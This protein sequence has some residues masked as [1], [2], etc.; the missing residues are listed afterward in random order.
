[1]LDYVG[2]G[3]VKFITDYVDSG[4]KG[5]GAELGTKG[6]K[7]SSSE[8]IFKRFFVKVQ[9]NVLYFNNFKE[10]QLYFYLFRGSRSSVHVI[11]QYRL[12]FNIILLT[13]IL[14]IKHQPWW[15]PI[16]QLT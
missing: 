6:F 11:N 2:G 9:Q 1:M 12:Y 15:S 13:W 8:I 5:G 4:Y 10:F 3:G 16:K 14:P 7:G